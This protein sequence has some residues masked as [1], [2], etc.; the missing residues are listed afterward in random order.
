MYRNSGQQHDRIVL[1]GAP[2]SLW[3]GR[4]RAYL[5]KK[6]LDYQ[7][8]YPAN[9]RYQQEILPQIGYF[10]V[11]VTELAD[12]TL[13][14][15]GT[16]TMEYLEQRYPERP[17]IPRLPVQRAVAWLIEFF[18]CGLG[19]PPRKLLEPADGTLPSFE[20]PAEAVDEGFFTASVPSVPAGGALAQSLYGES[21]AGNIFRAVSLV[22]DEARRVM[23]LVSQQYFGAEHLL[24]FH[25]TSD[26]ALSR[27][28]IEL[29]ATKASEHNQCF[30]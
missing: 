2:V 8:I 4:V 27:A 30:Y 15:D 11:P 14:Q 18:G 29:V 24:D 1:W 28:Q 16:D 19:L 13:I 23:S 21:P 20:R 10:V 22:P 6:G 12:G 9:P 25:A 26:H 5:I 7:E 17:M 3:T